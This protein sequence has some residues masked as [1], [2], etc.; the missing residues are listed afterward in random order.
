MFVK[1]IFDGIDRQYLIRSYVFSLAFTIFLFVI[2]DLY[3]TMVFF[4]ILNLILYPFSS[5][6]WDDLIVFLT[7]GN[8]MF[9][10]PIPFMIAWKFIKF[11][12][13]YIFALIIGPIGIIYILINNRN[14]YD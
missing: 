1:K 8:M 4:L 7:G 12:I 14:I 11:F 10:L 3:F 9:I 5:V 13:L 6:V 2:A